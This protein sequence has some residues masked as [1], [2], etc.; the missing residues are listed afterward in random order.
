[1]AF[2]SA[3]VEIWVAFVVDEGGEVGGVGGV[4]PGGDESGPPG[5]VYGAIVAAAP[6]FGTEMEHPAE[7]TN[8]RIAARKVALVIV[9]T[10]GQNFPCQKSKSCTSTVSQG[11]SRTLL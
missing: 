5:S 10:N 1:M 11:P 7:R 6:R 9:L 3:G 8:P 4:P 2:S